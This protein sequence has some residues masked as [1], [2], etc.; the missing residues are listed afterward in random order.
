MHRFV[1]VVAWAVV[2]LL[3]LSLVVTLVADAA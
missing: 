2:T 1:R 3:V